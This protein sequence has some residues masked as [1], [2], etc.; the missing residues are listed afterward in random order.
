M[1]QY[2]WRAQHSSCPGQLPLQQERRQDERRLE[3]KKVSAGAYCLAVALV[4][5]SAPTCRAQSGDSDLADLTLEQLSDITV[6]SAT[7]RAA[8]L[9]DT[10]ASIYVI[11]SDDIKRS[12][13]TNV[14]EALELAPNLEVSQVNANS[15]TVSA[16]GF[17]NP[18]TNKLLVLIDGRTV[19]SPI[20]SGVFWNVQAVMLDSVDR[21]EVTSGPGA[22]LSGGN[23]VAGVINIITKRAQDTTG[24]VLT[25]GA[26][27]NS[28]NTALQYGGALTDIGAWRIY[29]MHDDYFST[30]HPDGSDSNDRMIRDQVG[31]RID[32]GEL[33]G[34]NGTIQ[35]DAY[36]ESVGTRAGD[37]VQWDGA[38]VLGRYAQTLNNGDH[39]SAQAYLDN[40]EQNDPLGLHDLLDTFDLSLQYDLRPIGNN[41]ISFG[42]GYRYSWDR[43]IA[44][45]VVRFIPAD[46]VLTWGNLF[47][48]DTYAL[49]DSINLIAGVRLES[50]VYTSPQA[51]PDLRAAWKV[52][53]DSL[54]WAS[55]SRAVR[56]PSRVDRDFYFPAD[57]PYLIRGNDSFQSEVVNA[58]EVGYKGQPTPQTSFSVTTFYN[59]YDGLRSGNPSPLGG[60]IVTNNISGQGMGLEAWG[61]W[62]PTPDLRLNAGLLELRQ[63]LHTDAGSLDPTGPSAL[64][65]DP[66]HTIKLR[67]TYSFSPAV[68]LSAQF[69]YVS[70]LSYT[71]LVPA[72]NATDFN[73]R[74]HASKSVD[75][76]LSVTD[77]F[78]AEHVEFAANGLLCEIPREAYLELRWKFK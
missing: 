32:L 28:A 11:T 41:E 73:L 4:M 47:V 75:V 12:G 70:Q 61:S 67:G 42:G 66:R 77:A 57:P 69:R 44:T 26:G 24:G 7:K 76:S 31:F 36:H 64:G 38:N 62:Q 71:T 16:R 52:T 54:L 1:G 72:Y 8:K 49:T 53:Q 14:P 59:Q 25:A 3:S 45:P 29:G 39:F 43:T 65:N 2:D 20:L 35:G 46:R 68:E 50:D 34:S 17:Q 19:Y 74:W 13:A 48:Q 51:M 18:V 63:N 30:S 40:T 56:E 5:L 10:P 15:Y 27:G 33:S 23:A 78:H 21:I 6:S 9:S 58:L 37:V 22:A 60:Y 55:L